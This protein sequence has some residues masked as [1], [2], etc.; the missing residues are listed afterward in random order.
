MELL[1]GE[2][3][4]HVRVMDGD[5]AWSYLLTTASL[6]TRLQFVSGI[7]NC[8]ITSYSL[9]TSLLVVVSSAM[10]PP[11]KWSLYQAR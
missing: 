1:G 6:L 10:R 2:R 9:R 3:F 5:F 7:W 11:C 4:L 8:R